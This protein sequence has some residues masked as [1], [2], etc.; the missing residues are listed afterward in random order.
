MDDLRRRF[1]TLDQLPVPDLW[2]E[3][4]ER[5]NAVAT[6]TS[7]VSGVGA[8]QPDVQAFDRRILP[9]AGR[10]RLVAALVVLALILAL[11]AGVLLVSVGRPWM[12]RDARPFIVVEGHTVVGL[13]L[14]ATED[15]AMG[16]AIQ[17]DGTI[18]VARSTDDGVTISRFLEDGRTDP[19]FGGG[20]IRIR[21]AWARQPQALTLRADGRVVAVSDAFVVARFEPD[22]TPDRT[23]GTNGQADAQFGRNGARAHAIAVQDDG[24]IVV[25][26]QSEAQPRGSGF[27]PLDSVAMKFALA[28]LDED[29]QVDASFGWFGDGPV[30]DQAGRVTFDI[31]PGADDARAIA[32]S[33]DGRIVVAGGTGSL[34]PGGGDNDMAVA[35]FLST[36]AP[37]P[38]FGTD[39]KVE[40]H[41]RATLA[42]VADGIALQ[43]DGRMLLAGAC[44]ISPAIGP[45]DPVFAVCLARLLPDGRLDAT[46]GT[47]GLVR[48][49]E[50]ISEP[51]QVAVQRDG[52]VV[53]ATN[54]KLFRFTETGSVDRSFGNRG[55]LEVTQK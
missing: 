9:I 4:E 2:T 47:G 24:R 29:G 52:R 32:L 15:G 8:R 42:N 48:G 49:P 50:G 39:G 7:P 28:R 1:S 22:G 31:A 30:G 55:V 14:N 45:G 6:A 10:G 54:D 53:V 21:A 37:D 34:T 23:F 44:H 33:P 46:F 18:V 3:I 5:A 36:G 35:R 51:V 19:S 27:T 16:L 40:V 41:M 11:V 38:G 25:V 43:M 13:S 17:P 26:G 20:S 12:D